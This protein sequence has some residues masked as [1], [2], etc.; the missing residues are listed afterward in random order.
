MDFEMQHLVIFM[1]EADWLKI[2]DRAR[3]VAII[4]KTGKPNE[5]VGRPRIFNAFSKN[6]ISSGSQG[7]VVWDT[8]Y[9]LESFDLGTKKMEDIQTAKAA[10]S[11]FVESQ[12]PTGSPPDSSGPS[13]VFIGTMIFLGILVAAVVALGMHTRGLHARLRSLEARVAGG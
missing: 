10:Q 12:K 11:R 2:R 13:G 5:V 9:M 4:H 3:V 7:P 6:S 1:S 8:K